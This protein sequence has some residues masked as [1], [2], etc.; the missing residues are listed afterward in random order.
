MEDGLTEFL[1][2][3]TAD[4]FIERLRR[5]DRVASEQVALDLSLQRA[6]AKDLISPEDLPEKARST[7]DGYAVC[8]EDTFGA[9]DSIPALLE[10]AGA[11]EMGTIPD[12]SIRSGQAAQIPTGGFLP[13]G[14]NAVVMVEYTNSAGGNSIEVTRP[15]T[16]RTNVLEKGEDVRSGDVI[17]AAGRA[18]RPYEIGLC[19]AL[20]I[21]EVPAYRQPRVAVI[22]TGDEVVPIGHAPR[23][24]Q[25]RDANAHSI[26]ALIRAAGGETLGFDIIPDDAVKLR[27]ALEHGLAHADL[28]VLS[29]GSSVGTRDLMVEVVAGLPEAEVLAHGVSIRP[30]KPTLLAC[31]R[32]K[33]IIGLPGHPVSA[34]MVAQIFL[35]PFLKYLQGSA[36]KKGPLGERVKAVLAVSIHSTIGL[37]EYV[38]IRLEAGA[39]GG[40]YAYPIFGKSGMLSTMVKAGGVVVVPMHVEGLA[41]GELV[42]VI[43]I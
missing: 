34:L 7:V 1:H 8:A 33:P 11:V 36:L 19:A 41:K 20:G 31:Q 40:W 14:A 38:R 29:G 10:V 26:S 4:Q 6:L 42:E 5:F 27:R 39:D 35:T 28:V 15:L 18:L 2:V 16:V 25:I 32:G 13:A 43:H 9:S 21:T 12:F 24:G 23:P 30:G 22:S 3:I 17:V 37:E